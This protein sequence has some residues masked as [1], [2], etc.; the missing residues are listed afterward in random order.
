ML[1]YDKRFSQN[2]SV[3]CRHKKTVKIR[4]FIVKLALYLWTIF[5][6]HIVSWEGDIQT[7]VKKV[8]LRDSL[9]SIA[10]G[11][12]NVSEKLIICH[13]EVYVQLTKYRT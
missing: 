10:N 13:T 5:K 1:T 4:K 7:E 12:K 8:D 2:Q 11:Y 3:D 9:I 6:M